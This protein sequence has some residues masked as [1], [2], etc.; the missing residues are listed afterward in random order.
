MMV[1]DFRWKYAEKIPRWVGLTA[2]G[3][4]IALFFSLGNVPVLKGMLNKQDTQYEQA[5]WLNQTAPS[6]CRIVVGHPDTWANLQYFFNRRD[7]IGMDY[8]QEHFYGNPQP[9][10]P[11]LT[12]NPCL[13]IDLNHLQPE[14]QALPGSVVLSD[15]GY[16]TF[17]KWLFDLRENP[18]GI[19]VRNHQWREKDGKFGL[20]ITQEH[21]LIED[22]DLW[23][24]ELLTVPVQGQ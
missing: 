23:A 22:V 4:V 16:R 2:V 10:F 7:L 13:F 18:E 5:E 11:S 3:L 1:A 6:G 14:F 9:N 20:E 15:E 19:W 12:S 8:V 21:V 17:L 24:K